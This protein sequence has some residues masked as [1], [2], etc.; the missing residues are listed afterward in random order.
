MSETRYS[1]AL[2]LVLQFEGGFTDDPDDRGGA[3]NLGII[4]TEY[5]AYRRRKKAAPQSV[6]SITMA[7]A[8]EIY[9]RQY[10]NPVHAEELPAP[11]DLILFDSA[12]NC[13]VSRA[14]KWLQAILGVPQD[15]V[16]GLHTLDAAETFIEKRGA[17][18]LGRRLLARR[19]AFYDKIGV[20]TQKKFLHGWRNR[21]ATLATKTGLQVA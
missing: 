8:S 18:E 5:D 15:G 4:Q 7:E 1:D 10:W 2:K 14:A 11:V 19:N 9:Q 21:T 17:E 16:I 13:G 3:T 12:V 6:R 20:G